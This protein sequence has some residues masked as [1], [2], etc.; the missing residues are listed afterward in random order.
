[1][2]YSV[3]DTRRGEKAGFLQLTHRLLQDGA[4]MI[5]NENELRHVDADIEAA[6]SSLGGELLTWQEVNQ[7]IN[8]ELTHG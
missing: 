3:I 5:V 7:M 8:D 2:I 1:M 4:K 6:A